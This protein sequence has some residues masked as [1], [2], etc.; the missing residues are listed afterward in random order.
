M[1]IY[2]D[3]SGSFIPLS[4]GQSKFSAVAALMIP[5]ATRDKLFDEFLR[6]RRQI[7]KGAAELKGSQLTEKQVARVLGILRRFDVI[8]DASVIDMGEHS[9]EKINRIKMLQADKLFE[10]ITPEHQPTLIA[11]LELLAAQIRSLPDQLYVQSSLWITLLERVI[12]EM[13][14]YY[15]QRL[16]SELGT[17]HWV[18]DAK[19]QTV[20]AVEEVWTTLMLPALQ[21]RSR[22][23]PMKMLQE[24]DYS[25]FERYTM[26]LPADRVGV[27]GRFG[28]DIKLLLKE[29]LR[30][31]N[32]RDEPGLQIVDIL[33]SA[34]TRAFNKTL[35]PEGWRQLGHL[36]IRRNR[37]TVHLVSLV[38]E[39]V[40]PETQPYDHPHAYLVMKE[41][42]TRSRSMFAKANMRF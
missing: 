19:G 38:P 15:S 16:P 27:V 5:T 13:T 24:G 7:G 4:G 40:Y 20:T 42:E 12:E 11:Q 23:M 36:M 35:E 37:H 22:K 17:F 6:F 3:E 14:F 39:P 30:F 1:H 21:E 28:T 8:F 31:S 10:H 41:L 29:D 33:A 34:L 18:V 25:A 2:M 32:S 9:G 26:P